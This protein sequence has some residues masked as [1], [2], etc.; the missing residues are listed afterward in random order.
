MEAKNQEFETQEQNIQIN[1][2]NIKG[3]N[4]MT[5]QSELTAE[6]S[7]T[8]NGES[9]KD[10]KE[11]TNP[12]TEAVDENSVIPEKN[13]TPSAEV[14]PE[15]A[16]SWDFAVTA[17]STALCEITDI[18]IDDDGD[19]FGNS[20]LKDDVDAFL[21]GET[22]FQSDEHKLRTG[23]E[24]FQKFYAQHNRAWSGVKGTFAEYAVSIGIFLIA[25][26]SLMKSCGYKWEPWAAKNLPFI[27]PKTRQ[28]YMQLGKVQGISNH[29]H[30]GKERLLLLASATKGMD[31]DDPI[32]DFLK[33]YDLA[34]N[35]EEEIDLD[36]YKE[37]VDLALDHKRLKKA[38]IDV[39]MESL[40][41]YRADGKK[42]SS[43]LIERLKAVQAGVG[44]PN[45]YL[46]DPPDDDDYKDREKAKSFQKSATSLIGTINW[47][48]DR[49]EYLKGIEISVIDELADEIS[50]L[51]K[52]VIEVE[53]E[54]SKQ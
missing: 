35:P 43:N 10:I 19:L 44:D 37:A 49:K 45:E 2:N 27:N 8:D 50:K 54:K 7:G 33:T 53:A 28:T 36:A 51:K 1:N 14:E 23:Q 22:K 6:T 4:D 31:G 29:L 12:S 26:K 38:D 21:S 17:D 15:S 5:K 9:K 48:S 18:I 47:I 16:I 25:L 34:F 11:A 40:K 32:G 24:L 30:F 13:D 3:E 41:K 52:L 39:K 42:V 46:E 20:D